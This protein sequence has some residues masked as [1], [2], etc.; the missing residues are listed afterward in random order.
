MQSRPGRRTDLTRTMRILLL[1]ALLVG[2]GSTSPVQ[3][4]DPIDPPDA[5]ADVKYTADAA[6]VDLTDAA[7]A[8]AG[9]EVA[10]ADVGA[11]VTEESE[12]AIPPLDGES[13]SWVDAAADAG[14][15]CDANPNAPPS[16]CGCVAAPND[17][18]C[19]VGAPC[20]WAPNTWTAPVC[21]NECGLVR[22][23]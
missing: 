17:P 5:A 6:D 18:S 1:C 4:P 23:R 8:D 12:A 3:S 15:A 11:P 19:M 7:A 21:Q 14:A 16:W 20:R 9:A 22:C 13:D 10:A 2:C